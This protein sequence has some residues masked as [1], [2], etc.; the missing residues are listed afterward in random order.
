MVMRGVIEVSMERTKRANL[1][2]K[3]EQLRKFGVHVY[4][5]PAVIEWYGR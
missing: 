5:D 1:N 3:V 2:A 4:L